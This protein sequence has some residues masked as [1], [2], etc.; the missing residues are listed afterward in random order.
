MV[1]VGRAS[2]TTVEELGAICP[3]TFREI[4][5]TAGSGQSAAC[6]ERRTVDTHGTSHCNLNGGQNVLE[7]SWLQN[8][9]DSKIGTTGESLQFWIT[10][11]PRMPR[12]SRACLTVGRS[13]TRSQETSQE[14]ALKMKVEIPWTPKPN[15][16]S[17]YRLSEP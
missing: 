12:R 10:T 3:V 9:A 15:F 13:M 14:T 11:A 8:V 2:N 6:S 7:S 5:A 1:F 17:T 16:D 4:N